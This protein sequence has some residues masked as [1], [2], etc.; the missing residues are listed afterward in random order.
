[1]KSILPPVVREL[2]FLLRLWRPPVERKLDEAVARFAAT[3]AAYWEAAADGSEHI[4]I[5]GHLS[6]YGPN[7]LFRT[8]LAARGLQSVLGGAQVDVVVN[9]YSY[10]WQTAR[11]GY[12]S[13]GITRWVFLG[14]RFVLLGPALWLFALAGAGLNFL[15]L[16]A[17]EQI[18]DL[19]LGG[20]QVGDL[21]YDEIMRASKQP[22][23]RRVDA[24]A[25][26]V[27][28]RSWY[29]YLEYQ[30]LFGLKKYRY[31]L[32][33]HTAYPEYGLLCRVALQ[34]KVTVIET[35]DIQMSVYRSI[36]EKDLPTYHHGINSAI[37]TE[38]KSN[39]LP[40]AKREALARESLQ[41]RLNSEL[42]QI[43]AK[44]AYSGTVY[45]RTE[46]LAELGIA[47]DQRIGFVLAHVFVDSPHLSSSMLHADY[48][49]WLST[50]IDCCAEAKDIIWVV[51]PHPS[52]AL[53]GEDGMVN[54]LVSDKGAANVRVCPQ[55]LNTRSLA[56]CAD[57]ILTVHGT[58]GLE[59]S[60][61]GIPVVLA[62]T[63]FYAGFGFTYEPQSAS[64][65]A[66]L[67]R[68]A[69]SLAR[70]SPEQ[71]G[72]AL[73]VFEVWERQFDW[74]N[75]IITSELLASVW[76]NGAKRDL[77][78]AYDILTENLKVTDPRSLKLWSFACSV[79]RDESR[80]KETEG[81]ADNTNP[82]ACR[83]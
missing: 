77:K 75:S 81:N 60:C 3:N 21:V 62:G 2:A 59:Y 39:T 42:D 14:R 34:R 13:F 9:G 49:R 47:H 69:D 53:Y 54:A 65:Y 12:R 4:L 40:A 11:R 5:E 38:L 78:R 1:M 67:V 33:T 46:L 25:L 16:R 19:R 22:T 64:E 57:V 72:T 45:E 31:Y 36:G 18:V 55:D 17:P 70:L 10:Q 24:V 27:M 41:R 58:A 80:G 30:L 6:E 26:K 32:A 28:I 29:Y 44:K 52:C 35:S 83:S 8:A 51:K 71:I 66:D 23:V 7:Y 48:Y 76:G 74:K 73:Q 20:I 50:T 43:D 37:R 63:P 61:L 68:H 79:V 56:S 82:Q 15:R